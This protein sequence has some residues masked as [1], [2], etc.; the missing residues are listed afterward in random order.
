MRWQSLQKKLFLLCLFSFNVFAS[1]QLTDLGPGVSLYS[2]YYPNQSAK[3]KGTIIF[4]NGSGADMSEWKAN[5]KFF[6]CAKQ[7]GS[8]FLYDRNGLGK[9]PPDLQLSSYNPITAKQVND[10]LSA[11]LKKLNIQPPYIFVAHSY[12]AMYA[13]YFTLKNP[14]LV[15]GLLLVDPVPRDFNLADNLMKKYQEGVAEAKNNPA[16]YIYKKYNGQD[17]EVFYQLLGFTESKR[18]VKQLGAIDSNIPVIIISSTGMEKRH[19]LKEDWYTSQKQ[20]LNKNPS[21]KII[22]VTSGHYVQL[23]KPQKVCDELKG[24]LNLI[25]LQ[26]HITQNKQFLSNCKSSVLFVN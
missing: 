12:G 2:E 10:K 6:N 1:G 24:L 17:A 22:R 23:N 13:G 18:S 19:P 7:M 25:R 26:K 5:K 21:S 14:N 9:S 16:S 20:W 4:E 8:V 3:F 11:L 15:K